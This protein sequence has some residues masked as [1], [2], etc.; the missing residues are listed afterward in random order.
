M[1]AQLLRRALPFLS[2]L[3]LAAP[4]F[5][6]SAPTESSRAYGF[7][8]AGLQWGACPSFL[9]EGCEIAVLHGDPA[10]PN[11]DVFFKVPAGATIP[12]HR[13][14]SAER[15]VLVSG[16]LDVT[17]EGEKTKTLTSGMYAYGPANKPHGAVCAK[18]APCVLFIAFEEPLDAVPHESASR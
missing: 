5:A 15:M 8:D 4:V 10:Q 17:Y 7:Q 2:S 11:V 9:P 14:T 12:V 3:L 13:H 6:D 18:G 16:K 1:S